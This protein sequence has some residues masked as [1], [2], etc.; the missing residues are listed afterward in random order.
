MQPYS[1]QNCTHYLLITWLGHMNAR[2]MFS[3]GVLSLICL[4]GWYEVA[5]AEC[6]PAQIFALIDK[7]LSRAQI[8]SECNKAGNESTDPNKLIMRS[9][10]KAEINTGNISRYFDIKRAGCEQGFERADSTLTLLLQARGNFSGG[11]GAKFYN[12][13]GNLICPTGKFYC[14]MSENFYRH[15][16]K[17]GNWQANQIM[18]IVVKIPYSSARVEVDFEQQR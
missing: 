11:V 7:G 18:S 15:T 10:C 9:N 2:V 16:F 8:E 6:S 14:D 13:N 17:Y 4:L 12:A 5:T 3:R 1:K